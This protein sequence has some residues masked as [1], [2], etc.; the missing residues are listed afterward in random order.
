MIGLGTRLLISSDYPCWGAKRCI[1]LS[2]I[3]F[4]RHL[5]QVLRKPL[6]FPDSAASGPRTCLSYAVLIRARSRARRPRKCCCDWAIAGSFKSADGFRVER[7]APDAGPGDHH[8][9]CW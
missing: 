2:L 5:K 9:R 1:G 3:S 6:L 7:L 8:R 4:N